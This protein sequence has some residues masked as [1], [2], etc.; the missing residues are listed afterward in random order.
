MNKIAFSVDVDWVKEELIDYTL[1]LFSEYNIKVTLFCTHESPLCKSLERDSRCEISIHPNFNSVLSGKF[2]SVDKI[3][4]D[5]LD[6]YPLSKGVRSHSLLSSTNLLDKFCA[7][8]FR[9]ESNIF[10]P[11]KRGLEVFKLWN[12]M[13]SIPLNWEDNLHF[14]YR[15]PFD[16]PMIDI[17]TDDMY[18]LDFHPIHVFLNTYS[19]DHYLSFKEHYMDVSYLKE[20]VNK[21]T[22]GVRDCLVNFLE[23]IKR[24]KLK[25]YKM[26][27]LIDL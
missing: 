3:L 11:Y 12:N 2:S 8:G 13:Y 21:K 19:N 9:Y 14:F 23:T 7:K 16:K 15:Y 5:L 25:T 17:T 18:V 1:S 4:D 22:P 10:M 20:N 24:E 27:E 6:M 26:S